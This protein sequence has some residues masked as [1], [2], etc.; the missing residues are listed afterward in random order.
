[1]KK[2]FLTIMTAAFCV[3][4]I[5]SIAAP[6]VTAVDVLNGCSPS[7]SDCSVC[8][9]P[10]A[11]S[12]PVICTD[13]QN[14]SKQNPLLGPSGVLTVAANILSILVGV[15][16]IIVI[17]ISGLRMVISSGDP[18]SAGNARKAIIYALVGLAIAVLAQA[19][20]ALVLSKVQ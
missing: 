6:R 4:G 19:I 2:L 12:K 3:L 1:M 13:N 20:V 8:S 15:A 10:N 5:G 16:A 17:I 9:N 14:G 11:T 7:T 18:T